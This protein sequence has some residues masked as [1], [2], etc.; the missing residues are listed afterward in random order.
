MSIEGGLF[1]RLIKIGNVKHFKEA[2][3]NDYFKC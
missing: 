2:L 1:D 3:S